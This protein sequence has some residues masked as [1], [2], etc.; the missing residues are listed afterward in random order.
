MELEE[1]L[2]SRRSIRAY[3]PQPVEEAKLRHLIDAA[4][5]APS[6]FNEQPWSFTVVRDRPLLTRISAESKAGLLKAPSLDAPL[7]LQELLAD[8]DFDI[9]YGA[10]A[11]IVISS[12]PGPWAVVDCSLAAENLMLAAR[13]LGL[14]TCWI[15]FAQAWL[16]TPEGHAALEIPTHHVPVAPVIV[17]YPKAIPA[18]VPRREPEVRWLG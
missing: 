9:L 3:T 10:P 18:D 5:Q 1:A 14:G 17:G 16:A 15:G 8:P 2:F 11:L 4:I 12:I 7:H 13:A 6:A